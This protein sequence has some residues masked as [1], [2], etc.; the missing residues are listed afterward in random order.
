MDAFLGF[1]VFV[2]TVLFG[3]AARIALVLAVMAVLAVPGL[4]AAGWARG[5]RWLVAIR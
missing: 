2:A 3:F 5:A 4:V 1:L